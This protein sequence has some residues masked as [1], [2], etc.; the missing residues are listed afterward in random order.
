MSNSFVRW[1][2]AVVTGLLI[3]GSIAFGVRLVMPATAPSVLQPQLATVARTSFQKAVNVTGTVV[4]VT[5]A[6]VGFHAGGTI[7][8]INVKVGENVTSGTVL[9]T[10]ADP[11]G[12]NSVAQAQANLQNAQAQ[13]ASAQNPSNPGQIAQLQTALTDAQSNLSQTQSTVQSINSSDAQRIQEQQTLVNTAQTNYTNGG[14]ASQ[15]TSSNCLSLQSSLTAAQQV[16]ADLQTAQSKDSANGQL[17]VAH[18][19]ATVD[20][21][22]AALT[23]ASTP[24]PNAVA[25]AQAKV[26]G[27]QSALANASAIAAEANLVSP[28]NGTVLQ[29]NGNVGDVVSGGQ[30]TSVAL[31]GISAP[32]SALASSSGGTGSGGLPFI[33]IGT[34]NDLAVAFSFPASD[35]GTVSVG[36][37]AAVTGAPTNFASIDG[38]VIGVSQDTVVLG[39]VPSYYATMSLKSAGSL[40]AGETLD[41]SV[42]SSLLK[43][44]LSVPS[45][46]VYQLGGSPYVDVWNGKQ[47]VPTPI[48]VGVQGTRLVQVL[49][50]LR[51]GQQV[52]LVANQGFSQLVNP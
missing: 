28:I 16:L 1:F 25:A 29:I 30:P 33:V 2:V 26:S 15:P 27:A 6:V 47:G 19:Q 10:L 5:E 38:S 48:T 46:A 40:K 51:D 18:A 22:Q 43:N 45:S 9:A 49:G 34:P 7:S 12:A 11:N 37:S 41:V 8:S 35:L 17:Q 50:G 13:L 39:G 52:V 24:D 21:A 23:A 20:A 42:T 31:P 32:A 14:C 44:V 36:N 4:P 3:V